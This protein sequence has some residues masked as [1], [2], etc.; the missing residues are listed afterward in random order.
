MGSSVAC[1]PPTIGSSRH[2]NR[3]DSSDRRQESGV[4]GSFSV[5]VLCL[6]VEMVFRH[7][8]WQY[9][10]SYCVHKSKSPLTNKSVDKF[11]T[12]IIISSDLRLNPEKWFTNVS[13]WNLFLFARAEMVSASL[14]ENAGVKSIVWVSS[15]RRLKSHCPSHPQPLGFSCTLCQC[16]YIHT[17]FLCTSLLSTVYPPLDTFFRWNRE[18]SP[19]PGSPYPP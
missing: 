3:F 11:P 15:T 1:S 4:Y 19:D 10:P 17:R 14:P 12:K 8:W 6:L 9:V 7:I 2:R 13:F 18:I 5:C 16:V